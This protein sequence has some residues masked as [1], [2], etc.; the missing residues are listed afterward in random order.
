MATQFQKPTI[1]VITPNYNHAHYL[2]DMLET[3]LSQSYPPHEIILIDDGSTDNSVEVIE[4]YATKHPCIKLIKFEKN[5][6][7]IKAVNKGINSATGD[8]Y[9]FRS[10][11]DVSYPGFFEESIKMLLQYPEAGICCTDSTF[12]TTNY[13]VFTEQNQEWSDEPRFFTPFDFARTLKGGF[14]YGSTCMVK[15]SAVF[16]AGIYKEDLKWS[17]DWFLMLVAAFRHGVCYIPKPLSG[18]RMDP[19]GYA[20]TGMS[21]WFTQKPV[22]EAMLNYLCNEYADIK[23]YF[24]LSGC[25]SIFGPSMAEVV[26]SEP[27]YWTPD[28]FALILRPLWEWNKC[29]DFRK[30]TQ[31]PLHLKS[32]LANQREK[33]AKICT[34]ASP[35]IFVYGAG[36]HTEFLLKEWDE[37]DLPPVTKIVLSKKPKNN[38]FLGIPCVCIDDIGIGEPD[39]VMIS[40]FSFEKEMVSECL[41]VFPK[42]P[43]LTFWNDTQSSIEFKT[44]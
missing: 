3:T 12:F 42:A 2:P 40:S 35:R 13:K 7:V 31:I 1:S 16:D 22:T 24:A 19:K 21:D 26:L 10:A 5:Q 30:Q 34:K 37:L 43:R 39:L 4:K 8:Y 36:S 41:R 29:M 33:L 14:I 38:K 20:A 11:D 28:M 25:L 6:G 9:V 15:R 17:A 18:N 27:K 32:I 23:K 44:A